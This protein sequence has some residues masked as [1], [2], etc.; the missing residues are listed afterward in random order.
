MSL[1][2]ERQCTIGHIAEIVTSLS[3]S[4]RIN[5]LPIAVVGQRNGGTPVLLSGFL[6]LV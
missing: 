2:T 1:K 3:N 4:I 5:L 6:I